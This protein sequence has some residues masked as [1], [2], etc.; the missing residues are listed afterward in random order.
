MGGLPFSEKKER[1]RGLGREERKLKGE[2]GGL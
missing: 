1:M 2:K